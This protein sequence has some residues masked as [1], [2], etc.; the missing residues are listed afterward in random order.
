SPRN[1]RGRRGP[2]HAHVDVLLTV[3]EGP[4]AGLEYRAKGKTAI[5]VGRSKTTDFHILDQAMSRVHAVV[6][7]DADGWYVED[8][9]SRN[10]LWDGG[11]RVQ[12]IRLETGAVFHL[13]KTTSVR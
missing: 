7:R 4:R 3:V 13:G 6:A 10:G 5:T 2:Y 9:K 12:R 8:Q 1:W 11:E